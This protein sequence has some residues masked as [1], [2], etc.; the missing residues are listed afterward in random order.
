MDQIPQRP[1]VAKIYRTVLMS[2]ER[3]MIFPFR[4][5][6]Y[7]SVAGL[8]LSIGYLF[9]RSLALQVTI[10][11]VILLFDWMDGAVARKYNKTSRAGWLIDV[12]VDRMSEGIIFASLLFTP[13][14]SIFFISYICNIF[15]SFYSVKAGRHHLLPLRFIWLFILL[16]KLWM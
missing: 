9:A 11:A 16:G 6:A 15:L 1:G 2:L 14:G 3:Y 13:L 7:Y 4:D 10:I 5:P 12:A 8:L